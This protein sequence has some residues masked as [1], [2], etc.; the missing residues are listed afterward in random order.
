MAARDRGEQRP[1][2]CRGARLRRNDGDGPGV[3]AC[4]R[5]GRVATR[6]YDGVGVNG[7]RWFAGV[8]AS[9]G[10][11]GVGRGI[12]ACRRD[13]RVATRPYDGVRVSRG[14]SFAG[15]PA[16][17]GTTGAYSHF[18]CENGLGRPW[19]SRLPAGRAGRDPPLRW[20]RGE[21]RPFVCQGSRLRRN[22][23]G[24]PRGSRL[25]AGRAGR[26]PPLRWGRGERRPFVC[27]GSCLR[28]N[29]GGLLSLSMRE[30]VGA[31]AGFPPAGGTGGSRPAPTMRSG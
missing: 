27:R 7:G 29:D 26:D 1:F 18:P 11:T 5:D 28:R 30:R 23:G 21:Q 12:P 24:G 10:T 22:D 4:R 31:A 25:P 19:D 9:A 20:G 3:P 8:P 2:V 6:P 14:R 17:A 15:V 13:G 16:S